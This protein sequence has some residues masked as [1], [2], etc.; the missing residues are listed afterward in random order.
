MALLSVAGRGPGAGPMKGPRSLRSPQ[1]RFIENERSQE[2]GAQT[3]L[4]ALD[5]IEAIS[6][7]PIRLADLAAA[8]G[9]NEGTARRLARTLR[10]RNYLS[11]TE[12]G[13]I[14]GPKLLHLGA[15][16]NEQ[17]DYVKLV[18]PIVM[19]LC[20]R[21]GFCA[22]ASERNAN[23]SRHLSHSEGTHR[24]R[25]TMSSSDR[26]PIAETGLGRA[27][28]IDDGELEWIGAAAQSLGP[29]QV[30]GFCKEMEAHR[31]A[32]FVVNSAE[33]DGAACSISFPVRNASGTICLSIGIV[34]AAHYIDHEKQLRLIED[35]RYSAEQANYALG[36]IR[37]PS[38]GR[39]KNA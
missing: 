3:L 28:L 5:I 23:W 27:L 14:L 17:I 35:V 20:K 13:V 38:P 2:I 6:D 29:D 16:A 15:I 9:L 10:S 7:R 11:L 19:S 33:A 39:K 18:R 34:G 26:R 32:G 21:T 1:A 12:E 4:R 37:S 25:I 24:L 31:R 36:H 22:F 8:V 30:A